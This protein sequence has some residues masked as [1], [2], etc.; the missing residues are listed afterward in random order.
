MNR[1]EILNLSDE[2]INQLIA[3]KW[4]GWKVESLTDEKA[5]EERING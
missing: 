3:T 5:H 1:E 2:E 4:M